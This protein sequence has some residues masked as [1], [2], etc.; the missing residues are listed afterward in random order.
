MGRWMGVGG[1]VGGSKGTAWMELSDYSF[2][3]AMRCFKPCAAKCPIDKIVTM[4]LTPEAVGNVEASTTYN[5]LI[6]QDSQVGFS[7]L[8][9]GFTP[10]RQVPIWCALNNETLPA[11]KPAPWTSAKISL[12]AFSRPLGSDTGGR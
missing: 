4:G 2:A 12:S 5:P 6:S 10:I 3:L 8:L 9:S 7:T 11:G 1:W